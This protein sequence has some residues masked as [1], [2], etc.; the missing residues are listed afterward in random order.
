M[1]SNLGFSRI[2]FG[3]I[4][5]ASFVLTSGCATGP[6]VT[7]KNPSE[8][9]AQSKTGGLLPL[10]AAAGEWSEEKSFVHSGTTLGV[11][12]KFL[13]QHGTTCHYDVVVKNNGNQYISAQAGLTK[14][15]NPNIYAATANRVKLKPGEAV[16]YE[17]EARECGLRFGTNTE[18]NICAGCNTA[19]KFY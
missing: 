13:K 14:V 9:V 16:T 10:G 15:D 11:K 1:F 8:W 3:L 19:I 18:M 6:E 2:I 5:A 7:Y 4:S 12:S 17:Y